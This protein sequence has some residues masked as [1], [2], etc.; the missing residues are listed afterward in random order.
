MELVKKAMEEKVGEGGGIY[1][2]YQMPMDI[3]IAGVLGKRKEINLKKNSFV[4]L[5]CGKW[6]DDE[7][8]NHVLCVISHD[9]ESH[10]RECSGKNLFV[11]SYFYPM[12]CSASE[13]EDHCQKADLLG[14][15]KKDKGLF[16]YEKI[17]FPI[18]ARDGTHWHLLM[19]DVNKKEIK[20]FDSLAVGEIENEYDSEMAMISNF[21]CLVSSHT[22]D[23]W[24][25][26]GNQPC[27]QQAEGSGD[28]G[29][30]TLLHAD[31]LARGYS[32]FLSCDSKLMRSYICISAIKCKLGIRFL[33]NGYNEE[34]NDSA[35]PCRRKKRM[36]LNGKLPAQGD[37]P[38]NENSNV[39]IRDEESFTLSGSIG[40]SFD[41]EMNELDQKILEIEVPFE[42]A[43]TFQTPSPGSSAQASPWGTGCK[44]E[45]KLFK[46]V[47][48]GNLYELLTSNCREQCRLRGL[49]S[50]LFPKK[51]NFRNCLPLRNGFRN[52]IFSSLIFFLPT[53]HINN[54]YV[55]TDAG[56][57]IVVTLQEEISG[58][59]AA[60]D[61]GSA[62]NLEHVWIERFCSRYQTSVMVHYIQMEEDGKETD[63]IMESKY[64]CHAGMKGHEN[65][66]EVR[67]D[68]IMNIMMVMLQRDTHIRYYLPCQGPWLLDFLIKGVFN[69]YATDCYKF[70][71]RV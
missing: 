36:K 69:L 20:I 47:I 21:L 13:N 45:R 64:Y 67:K 32:P 57:N 26:S 29:L 19:V 50:R 8:I 52:N 42:S 17:F 61:E 22:A 10:S 43:S 31:L 14:W 7:M 48:M 51:L 18:H 71:Q 40:D 34:E 38:A 5:Q 24:K 37:W 12:W 2:T 33:W 41:C 16:Q 65:I 15:F 30:Y 49:A 9:L 53:V 25:L 39:L 3:A 46:D 11:S 27:T 55:E 56:V 66:E 70:H 23:E 35:L 44:Q 68:N 1:V 63:K 4:K 28:C 6:L 59:E 60:D 58:S 54:L 62:G